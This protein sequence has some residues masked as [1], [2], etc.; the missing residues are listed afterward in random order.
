M[1]GVVNE[2]VKVLKGAKGI[3]EGRGKKQVLGQDIVD[4][5]L[6]F[7]HG[8]YRKVFYTVDEAAWYR[9]L[10]ESEEQD[11]EFEELGVSD[12][13]WEEQDE[14]EVAAI[15]EL[16]LGVS[17]PDWGNLGVQEAEVARFF[18]EQ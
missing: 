12:L 17:D 2:L 11:V 15:D 16:E 6:K 4:H 18:K 10:D 8:S 9:N 7:H 14:A 1:I 3:C 13:E 5:L